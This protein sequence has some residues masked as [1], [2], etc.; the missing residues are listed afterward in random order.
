MFRLLRSLFSRE[1]IDPEGFREEK[2]Q[3]DFSSPRRARFAEEAGDSHEAVL[4]RKGLELRLKKRNV[5]AWAENPIHRYADAVIDAEIDFPGNP[6]YSAAGVLFRY[7]DAAS[8]CSVLVS[9]KGY[10]R[11]ET[12]FNGTPMP[13]VAWTELSPV[14]DLSKPV[15]LKIIALGDRLTLVV[16]GEWAAE[17]VDATLSAGHVAFAAANYGE[18]DRAEVRLLSFRVDSRP[19]D[20]EA[21]HYR[22]SAYIRVDGGARLRLAETFSAMGQPMSA[23]IQL[24]RAWKSGP[25]SGGAARSQRELLLAADCALRLSLLDEAEE[26][27]DRCVE[28]DDD[29]EEARRAIAEKA[30]LLY[31]ANRFAELRDHAEAAAVLYPDDPTLRTLLGHA[32]WNL[33]AWTRAAAEYERAW[34][35]APE[36]PIS[37]LNAAR[38]ADKLG[39]GRAAFVRYL[40]AARG[41]FAAEAWDDLALAMPRLRELNGADPAVRA[42]DG[43]RAFAAEDW[44]TAERELSAAYRAAP[45]A[46]EKPDPALPYLL[47]LLRIRAGKRADALPFLE[48]A[49]ELEGAYPPFLFRLAE[50]RFL[51]SGKADD[52]A[53]AREL[54]LALERAPGDGWI[55]NLAGQVALARGNLDEAASHLDRAASLLPDS[56]EVAANRAELAYLRGDAAQA[57]SILG[58]GA[59]GRSP[60]P[61]REA[62]ILAN[63]AGNILVR[64]ER[65]DEADAA[66]AAALA[67]VPGDGDYLRNRASCL[68]ELGRYGEADELLSRALES[69]ED[70]GTLDLIAYV[71]IKK[72]EYPRAEAAYRIGLEKFPENSVLLTG[73]AWTYATMARWKSAREAIEALERTVPADSAARATVAE[74]RERLTEATT[75]RVACAS[76][77][78]TWRVPKDAP[79]QGAIRLVAEPPDEMPAGNCPRCGTAYCVGCGKRNLSE[80]RFVCPVCGERLKLLDEGL[81]KILID[82]SANRPSD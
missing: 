81:K 37:A 14:T 35:L 4:G 47:G 19:I 69:G 82:W 63:A 72:G 39:D 41:F 46:G 50:T 5:F 15:H 25:G 20:V 23:L 64:E 21:A 80:G 43:K 79:S 66:Y 32:F 42:L 33:G 58:W 71:A 27:L 67:A 53:L 2:W 60:R 29:T 17:V 78:R 70:P 68:V 11:I 73:L 55:A 30:K 45:A 49:V 3:A 6:P 77:D 26:Y 38:A 51:L 24:K 28:A 16:N 52:P 1:E 76:C 8:Y 34:N 48:R 40:A 18:A 57:L 54:G 44:K 56:A 9:T 22:W 12:V 31:L 61:P 75:R 74:L 13:L 59:A 7:S 65:W 10:F 36:S 62:A